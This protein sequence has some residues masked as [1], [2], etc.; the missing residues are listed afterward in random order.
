M[1]V[2]FDVL[3]QLS[4]L[5]ELHDDQADCDYQK[6]EARVDPALDHGQ[7]N[8]IGEEERHQAV[9]EHV[10]QGEG[11]PEGGHCRDDQAGDEEAEVEPAESVLKRK[12]RM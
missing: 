4:E 8:G 6:Q 7:E 1:P 5:F 12:E 10:G 11:Q 2:I 3:V 9:R